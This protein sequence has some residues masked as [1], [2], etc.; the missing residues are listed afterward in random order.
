LDGKGKARVVVWALVLCLFG[1]LGPAAAGAAQAVEETAL[2]AGTP[3]ALSGQLPAARLA[4]RAL[5]KR[6]MLSSPD[7]IA[8]GLSYPEKEALRSAPPTDL[9]A[10]IRAGLKGVRSDEEA[11]F[12][13]DLLT[14]LPDRQPGAAAALLEFF[15]SDAA[16]AS[17]FLN[18]QV[19]RTHLARFLSAEDVEGLLE[20]LGEYEPGLQYNLIAALKS[21]GYLTRENSA[22]LLRQPGVDPLAVL[23]QLEPIAGGKG[24]VARA[25]DTF[26]WLGSLLPSLPVP[27]Q[28]S[29][30]RWVGH[31]ARWANDPSVKNAARDWLKVSWAG[32]KEP[33][34]RQEL[35]YQLYSAGAD[36]AALGQLVAEVEKH[37][38][39]WGL[40]SWRDANL[41]RRLRRDYPQSFLARG[42]A[43]YEKVRGRPY[44]VLDYWN[45]NSPGPWPFKYGNTQYHPAREIPGWQ[46][47]LHNFSRHPGADDAA[48]RLARCYEIEGQWGEA[49]TW[50]ARAL[51]LPDGDMDIGARGRLLFVLDARVPEAELKELLGQPG[52][53]PELRP[54]LSYT[55]AV[56]ELRAEHYQ[57]AAARLEEFLKTYGPENPAQPKAALALLPLDRYPF[58]QR[59]QEQQQQAARLAELAAHTEQPATLYELGAAVYHN[60]LTY[61]NHLWAGE[62]QSYNWLGHINE[63]WAEVPER[64]EYLRGLINFW[65]ALG[66]FQA[67]EKAPQASPELK[68]KALYSQGLALSNIL[69]WGEEAAL[70]FDRKILKEMLIAVFQRF[71]ATYPESS[72]ADDALFTLWAYSR[73]TTYL[74][75]LVATYPNGDRAAAAQELM[76]QPAKA[77]GPGS[78]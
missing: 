52:V 44:F 47:F 68:A 31:Q 34:L 12:W 49:L 3:A 72:M 40:E 1:V 74:K 35:L 75:R 58:W 11:F 26:A 54:L 15:R 24:P 16:F 4:F 41:L 71:V 8:V 69:E 50:Y 19:A 48:Y 46:E 29:V 62:R 30:V 2:P 38:A 32:A 14:L 22:R 78:P 27:N 37:G 33:A 17:R 36:P 73:D 42:F 77:P 20:S 76:R 7:I 56:R 59:V 6:S 13:F 51:S 18:Y 10:A 70:T 21:R 23:G 28:T 65:H 66:Y 45:P 60:K 9:L 53:A 5:F 67:V 25:S 64:E 61:Y 57:E 55:L 39:A 63:L 43:A